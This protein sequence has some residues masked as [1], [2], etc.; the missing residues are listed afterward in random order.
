MKRRRKVAR[1]KPVRRRARRTATVRRRARRR[2]G[3]PRLSMRSVQNQLVDAGTGAVGALGLD[4]IQGYLP[5]PANLKAGIIGT[6]VKALLAIGMGVVASKVKIVRGATA[7]KMVNGALTV[8]LHDELKKQVGNFAPGLQLGEYMGDNGMGYYGSGY[9]AGI[10][11]EGYG[12][13]G[14]YLPELQTDDMGMEQDGLGLYE[15][16]N[17]SEYIEDMAYL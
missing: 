4:V 8:V 3:N 6:G 11:G 2:V 15:S 1:K 5:I 7:N 16:G 17:D 10:M 12:G 13:M 14:S 9:P